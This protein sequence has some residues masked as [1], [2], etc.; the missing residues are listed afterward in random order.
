MDVGVHV[1]FEEIE[2]KVMNF[3]CG[4]W[5]KASAEEIEHE[6]AGTKEQVS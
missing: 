4:S 3:S 1:A 5:Q 6:N 2:M